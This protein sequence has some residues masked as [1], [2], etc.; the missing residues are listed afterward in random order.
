MPYFI[1][2]KILRF[3]RL[4]VMP[5]NCYYSNT[6]A[7]GQAGQLSLPSFRGRKIEYMAIGLM[8]GV[9]TFVG[10]QATLRDPLLQLTPR[11]F[12][13]EFLPR[14]ATP[15]SYTHLTLPTILRV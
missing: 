8:R 12:E 3:A 6:T 2:E 4:S 5:G 15:V 7:V 9:F 1:A 11:R 14:D 13:M 10:W